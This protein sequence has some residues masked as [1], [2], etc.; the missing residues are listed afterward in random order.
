VSK[1]KTL[2]KAIEY[3][4]QLQDLLIHSDATQALVSH[5]NVVSDT[6]R[7]TEIGGGDFFFNRISRSNL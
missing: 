4:N 6:K 5:Q 2:H 3:I 1:V 7:S